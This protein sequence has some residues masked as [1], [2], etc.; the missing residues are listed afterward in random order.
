M[1]GFGSQQIHSRAPLTAR[2]R[3]IRRAMRSKPFFPTFSTAKRRGWPNQRAELGHAGPEIRT[4]R[5][6]QY[7]PNL[8][9][10]AF[11]T[12]TNR[13]TFKGFSFAIWACTAQEH[14]YLMQRP[15]REDRKAAFGMSTCDGRPELWIE[16]GRDNRVLTRNLSELVVCLGEVQLY[17]TIS[18]LP[19]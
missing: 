15:F 13:R 17:Y 18:K 10:G 6:M 4:V 11:Q 9:K 7:I 19:P 2:R 16:T 3:R 8:Q 14:T 1:N 5:W 12:G